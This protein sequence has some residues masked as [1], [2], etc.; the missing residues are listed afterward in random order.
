[1]TSDQIK[2]LGPALTAFLG[3]FDDC[4]A[5]ADTR[6]HLPHYVH[7]QL[8]DLPRKSVEPMA[9]AAGVPP[10]TLQE[11]LS[12]SDWDHGLLRDRVQQVLAR[13]HAEPTP[14]P[15]RS[16]SSTRAGTPRR[17]TTPP[18]SSGST[19]GTPARSTTA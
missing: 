16:G 18:P 19:A 13:D 15:T 9:I 2:S 5:N 17:G 6:A 8:S 10:R 7:G 3:E 12:L 1:M 4:F 11:F 14:S